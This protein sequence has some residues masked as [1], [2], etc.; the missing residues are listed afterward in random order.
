MIDDVAENSVVMVRFCGKI[1]WFRS[2][3]DLWVLDIDK[4]RNEFINHGYDVP[5]FDESYRFGIRSVNQDNARIFLERMSE[6]EVDRDE[7][8]FELAGRFVGA[9]SWWD[10]KDLFPIMFVDFDGRRVAAFYSEGTP[11][12]RYIPDGWVGEFVDFAN[13]Y[14][15]TML[16]E[17]EK[18]WVRA[19][20]DLLRLLNERGAAL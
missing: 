10:V 17:G 4:W 15:E 16:P 20:S 11:M 1:R 7:L 5:D 8:S 9:K 14:D 12:E 13:E 2:D 6:F 3:R 18:F 19:G